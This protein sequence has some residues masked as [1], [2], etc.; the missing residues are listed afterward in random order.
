MTGRGKWG[1]R[2]GGGGLRIVR[3]LLL[4]VEGEGRWHLKG[5]R[6]VMAEDVVA[7]RTAFAQRWRPFE[8]ERTDPPVAARREGA[9]L[10]RR[11]GVGGLAE[12]AR[13][14]RQPRRTVSRVRRVEGARKGVGEGRGGE[15]RVK[16]G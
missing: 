11:G 10:S 1:A 14:N 4:L 15:G 6:F 3:F 12:D 7:I 2:A 13:G 16:R 8:A 9:T 5:R